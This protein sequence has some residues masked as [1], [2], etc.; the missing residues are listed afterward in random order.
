MKN[1]NEKELKEIEGGMNDRPFGTSYDGYS[2]GGDGGRG[3]LSWYQMIRWDLWEL[4]ESN[5]Y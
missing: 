2:S 5:W 1:L 4:S 3:S